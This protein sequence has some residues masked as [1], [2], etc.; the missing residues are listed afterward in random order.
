M[1]IKSSLIQKKDS[2]G[3]FKALA[4]S[5]IAMMVILLKWSFSD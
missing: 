4:L 1:I 2:A 5:A 3:S